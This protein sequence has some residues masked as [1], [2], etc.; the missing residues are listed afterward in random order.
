MPRGAFTTVI[1]VRSNVATKLD[2]AASDHIALPIP[3]TSL[4]LLTRRQGTI[5][6]LDAAKDSIVADLPGEKNPNSATYD[7]V[8][9]SVLVMNKGSGTATIVDPFGAKVLGAI[10]IS[11]DTLEFPVADGAGHV[12]D[13]IE[14][15]GEI[16]DLDVKARKV[17]RT[18]KLAGCEEPSGL[19][20]DHARKLLIAACG[21]GLAKVVDRVTGKEVASLPIG[22]GPDAVIYD[23]MRKMAFV[24]C[25]KDGVLTVISLSD[26]AKIAVA[27]T[28][29]TQKGTRTGTIDPATGRLYLMGAQ[30]DPAAAGRPRGSGVPIC[31]AP[32]RCWWSRQGA[33]HDLRKM[34]CGVSC[35]CLRAGRLHAGPTAPDHRR[36]ELARHRA[37]RAGQS[38]AAGLCRQGAAH[39]PA[40]DGGVGS[41]CADAGGPVLQPRRR[42]GPRAV[43]AGQ[44]SRD[45]RHCAAQSGAQPQR[46]L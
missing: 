43:G 20:Y 25:G 45:H 35:P 11:K 4:L 2:N 5:R 42:S 12:F 38:R 10:A 24:P 21:N 1:D 31:R 33:G 44:S 13:N 18:I 28:V 26:R 7:P 39:A 34:G 27:Q 6:I 41:R 32:S 37:T 30:I 15:T 17:A 22:L 40:P 9:K 46:G 16:A 14:T 23:P 8:T 19:A 3:G 36:N 29:R